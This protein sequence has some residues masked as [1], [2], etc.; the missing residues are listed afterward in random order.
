ME[1]NSEISELL[2][3]CRSKSQN[4]VVI[5]NVVVVLGIKLKTVAYHISTTLDRLGVE[6]RNEAVS[7]LHKHFPDDLE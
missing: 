6:S 2:A 1:S 7:W 4:V 5:R 3:K